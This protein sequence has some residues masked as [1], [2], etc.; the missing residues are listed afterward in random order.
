MRT[1]LGEDHE[2]ERVHRARETWRQ[3]LAGGVPELER[4]TQARNLREVEPMA[5]DLIAVLTDDAD[6]ASVDLEVVVEVPEADAT[7]QVAVRRATR[8]SRR[9][10]GPGRRRGQRSR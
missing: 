4:T 1:K 10:P 3:R 7:R 9:L 6:P 2:G 5:R 8:S